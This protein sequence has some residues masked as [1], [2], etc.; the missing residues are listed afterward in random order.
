M[1]WFMAGVN[2]GLGIL[3]FLA[4]I[5]GVALLMFLGFLILATPFLIHEKIR[6]RRQLKR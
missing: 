6:E 4:V 3:G 1:E 2:L 5:G